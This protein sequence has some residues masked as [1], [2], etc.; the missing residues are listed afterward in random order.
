VPESGLISILSKTDLGPPLK[1]LIEKVAK[2]IGVPGTLALKLPA[3]KFDAWVKEIEAVGDVRAQI[4]AKR[5]AGTLNRLLEEEAIKYGRLETILG[6][7]APLLEESADPD[8]IDDDWLIYHLEKARLVSNADM[9]R[10]WAKVLAGEANK[11]GSFSKRSLDFLSTLERREA[12]AFTKLGSFVLRHSG[13]CLPLVLDPVDPFYAHRGASF[14]ELSH[15]EAIGVIN[16]AP[17]AGYQLS[18]AGTN[19]FGFDYFGDFRLFYSQ[20]VPTS[21]GHATAPAGKA[22][23]TELGKQF[24]QICGAQPIEGFWDYVIEKW[25]SDKFHLKTDLPLPVIRPVEPREEG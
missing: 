20:R 14:D 15:F 22:L 4:A 25:A 21:A 8:A 18:V 12:E 7:T 1:T 5:E 23:F 16:F 3:A 19:L 17:L 10:L 13:G 11:P 24:F 6:E 2:L 9:Q